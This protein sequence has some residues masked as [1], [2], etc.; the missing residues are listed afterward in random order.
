MRSKIIYIGLSY[1]IQFLNIILNLIFMQR[2]PVSVLGNLAIAKVWLQAFD[3]THLGSRFAL[4][5]F[6][7][8]T[9]QVKQ[10]QLYLWIALSIVSV[11][12]LFVLLTSFFIE[13]S[14]PVVLS[15]CLVGISLAIG[16]VLK[17]YFRATA[18]IHQVNR[19]VA[20]LYVLPLIIS[21]IAA[22]YDYV[23]FLWVYPFSFSFVLIC[24]C[25]PYIKSK[26][27]LLLSSFR[28]RS[29][30]FKISSV[31]SLLFTNSIIIYF[32]L[33]IDRLFVDWT[34]GRYE[35]GQYSII[36]FVFSSLFTIPSILTELIFPK[37]VREVV[38][39]RKRFF[40][41]ET[42]FVF[43]ATLFMIVVANVMMYLFVDKYTSH[44]ELIPLMQLASLGVLPYSA[45]SILNHVFNGLDYRLRLVKINTL[46]LVCYLAALAAV[47]ISPTLELFLYAKISFSIL[48]LFFLVIGL[49]ITR[50][51]KND[52]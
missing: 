20:R 19:I 37:I 39:N 16:N 12:S 30:F 49:L 14:N 11:G 17:A 29:T 38:C 41:K 23:L 18:D 50:D 45:T 22:T 36:M 42:A 6:L 28:A 9:K 8:V 43:F 33:I 24:F 51:M 35:L 7:P 15:F 34:L 46:L 32:T 27:Y 21:V 52:G 25:V 4:D 5:R 48:S 40:W 3:Y 31:S 26:H 2:L 44:A 10:R 13:K 1:S 47:S